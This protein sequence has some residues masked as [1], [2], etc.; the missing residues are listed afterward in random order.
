MYG[1]I[2]KELTSSSVQK[3]LL[4]ETKKIAVAINLFYHYGII[5]SRPG[6]YIKHIVGTKSVT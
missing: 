4:V 5:T 1:V 3:W 6:K 2:L